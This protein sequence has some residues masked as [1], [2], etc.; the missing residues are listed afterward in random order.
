MNYELICSTPL[1]TRRTRSLLIAREFTI[2]ASKGYLE[3]P[4]HHASYLSAVAPLGGGENLWQ[5]CAHEELEAVL[6][7]PLAPDRVKHDCAVARHCTLDICQSETGKW[8][9]LLL[10]EWCQLEWVEDVRPLWR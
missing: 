9:K 1:L 6:R 7:A 5:L 10:R 4:P 8:R 2:L 3:G